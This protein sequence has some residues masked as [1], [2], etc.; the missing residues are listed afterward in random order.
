MV[1]KQIKEIYNKR[2][3]RCFISSFE[4]GT[5]T[6]ILTLIISLSMLNYAFTW[7]IYALLILGLISSLLIALFYYHSE[8]EFLAI[9]PHL[10]INYEYTN[11][12]EEGENPSEIDLL[13][14]AYLSDKNEINLIEASNAL[15]TPMSTILDR[16]LDL[17]DKGYLR[18]TKLEIIK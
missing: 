16:I 13:I 15:E 3:K 17:E 9:A 8:S 18:I 14:S 2:R 5:F 11:K 7:Q 12:E 6:F 1:N 4:I 10:K